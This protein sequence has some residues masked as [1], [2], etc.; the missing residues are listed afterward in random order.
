MCTAYLRYDDCDV[1]SHVM[2]SALLCL[3][4]QFSSVLKGSKLKHLLEMC[5][6]EVNKGK[7]IG[8]MPL[9]GE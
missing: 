6:L 8:N 1:I 7:G 9:G 3:K 5:L 2:I 4:K